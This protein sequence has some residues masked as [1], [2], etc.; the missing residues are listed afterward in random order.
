MSPDG[1]ADC[2]PNQ[3]TCS[4][5]VML[6]ILVRST[7]PMDETWMRGSPVPAGICGLPAGVMGK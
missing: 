1:P 4:G 7:Y 6:V 5:T 3:V 2:G